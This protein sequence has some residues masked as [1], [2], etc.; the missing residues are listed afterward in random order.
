MKKILFMLL[1]FIFIWSTFALDGTLDD[2]FDITTF[3]WVHSYFNYRVPV[4]Q[5]DGK[6]LLL[7]KYNIEFPDNTESI[8]VRLN[9]DGTLDNSFD[10]SAT[11]WWNIQDYYSVPVIQSDGKILIQWNI[12]TELWYNLPII[13][14]NPDGTLDDTFD[15]TTFSWMYAE[16]IA[17]VP[18]VYPDG[19][20]LMYWS[21]ETMKWK[22]PIIRLNSDGTLD[23]SF[24]ITTLSWIQFQSNMNT[25]PI[26]LPDGKILIHWSFENNGKMFPVMRLNN[27]WSI[28]DTFDITTFSWWIFQSRSASRKLQPDGK[29]IILQPFDDMVSWI[30]TPIIRLNQDGTLDNSFDITT[31]SWWNTQ[32]MHNNPALLP[33]GKILLLWEMETPNN[34]RIPIVRLN[35]DGTL[36]DTFDTTTFSWWNVSIYDTGPILQSDGKILLLWGMEIPNN[37]RIP[38]VR[39]N[40]DGTLDDTFDTTTFSWWNFYFNGNAPVIQANGDILLLWNMS[41][42]D[43]NNTIPIVRLSSTTLEIDITSPVNGS[44]LSTGTFDVIWTSSK[45]LVDIEIL[46]NW[47]TYTWQSNINW[48]YTIN[49]S[50]LPEWSYDIK[51]FAKESASVIVESE[52]VNI[53]I[54][55]P[56][57]PSSWWGWWYTRTPDNCP[58]GDF[59]DSRY[60][61]DCGNAEWN[62]GGDIDWDW[63]D[64]NTWNLENLDGLIEINAEV[65]ASC[66]YIQDLWLQ[67]TCVEILQEDNYLDRIELA[68]LSVL[69]AREELDRWLVNERFECQEYNDISELTVREQAFAINACNMWIMGLESDSTTPQ[70][71]FRPYDLVPRAEFGTVL[72]RLL[73]WAANNPT[74]WE[75]WYEWHLNALNEIGV[76]NYINNPYQTEIYGYAWLMLY[77]L[78]HYLAL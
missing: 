50:G 42:P 55:S 8:I 54:Q 15:S 75:E 70:E 19:K 64:T 10:T 74:E 22:T 56:S 20:I 35:P 27:D 59:S 38:I 13:R 68:E 29:I 16:F 17:S 47:I 71:N 61:S 63:E 45:P 62:N 1:L 43:G 9:P 26:P 34:N 72:S 57:V 52:I 12:S 40:P 21:L 78:S 77:R 44:V 30:S 49:I 36:D 5:S 14:L 33:D 66:K 28:D 48:D 51:A 46:I 65:L 23:N 11:S 69:F 58:D 24:D 76:M 4:I 25:I 7:W 18:L 73:R 32:F 39:L 31:F 53:L 6:I 2:T 67:K 60:D 37:N 41:K 3:S